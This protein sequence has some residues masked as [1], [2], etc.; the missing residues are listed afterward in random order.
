MSCSPAQGLPP[1]RGPPGPSQG[2]CGLYSFAHGPPRPW[3]PSCPQHR[4]LGWLVQ[5]VL[6][7]CDTHFQDTFVCG[8]C[9]VLW[10]AV[11]VLLSPDAGDRGHLPAE[12]SR[13][14]EMRMGAEDPARNIRPTAAPSPDS[15]LRCH[16]RAQHLREV[17]GRGQGTTGSGGRAELLAVAAVAARW[18]MCRSPSP[19]G[20]RRASGQAAIWRVAA[21]A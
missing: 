9:S 21:G 14:S 15:R 11:L 4:P 8:P 17:R 10:L 7:P 3:A 18:K 19:S 16:G 5:A 12:T 20:D 1:S 13:L 6:L 2:H